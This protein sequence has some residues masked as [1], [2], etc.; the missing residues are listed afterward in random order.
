MIMAGPACTVRSLVPG[1]VLLTSTMEGSCY[2]VI[3]CKSLKGVAIGSC[4]AGN[5]CCVCKYIRK[6]FMVIKNYYYNCL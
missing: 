5:V 1:P 6:D 4:G 3:A 2:P